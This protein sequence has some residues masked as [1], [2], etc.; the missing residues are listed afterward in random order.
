MATE[1]LVTRVKE[2]LALAKA[3][4]S[5]EAFA[6]YKELFMSAEFLTYPH[7]ERRHAIKLVVNAKVPPTRPAPSMVQAYKAAMFPLKK[8]IDD[9]NEPS[10][11]EL[12]GICLV[13]AGD[14]KRAA[15]HFRTGL[16]LERA[17]NPQS[18]LCGSLMK[19]NAAV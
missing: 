4:K 6:A 7:D 3:G 16:Q 10:D 14:E 19:W 13:V 1:A 5:D 8:M 2:I 9:A 15:E 11:H 12:M 17:K 18:D